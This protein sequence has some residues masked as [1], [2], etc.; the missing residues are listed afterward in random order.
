MKPLRSISVLATVLFQSALIFCQT[1]PKDLPALKGPYLGQIPP[2]NKSQIFAPD[3][4]STE[5]GE[6][7]SV[8]S[9]DGEE[10]YFSRRGIPG[11]PSAI[12]VT[13]MIN[14][15][16]TK[17]VPVDFSGVYD[18]V[19]LFIKPDGKSMIYCSVRIANKADMV[20]MDHDFL[21]SERVG[22]SWKSPVPFA[23]EATSAFEDY[24]PVVTESGNL[25]FNSQRGGTGT[26]DIFC[27]RYVNGKYLPAEKLPEPINTIY[28][29]F[30]AFVSQDEKMIIF[31]S[32]KPGGFGKADIYIS[33]K[34]SE[35][36][37]S[38]PKNPGNGINS[39]FSEY[40]ATLSPD[41]RYLFFTSNKNGSEDIFWVSAKFIEELRLKQ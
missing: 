7:N 2:G 17:P 40:G 27:S 39:E 21:M 37:W 36:G 4:V 3:F 25:Y 30:D 6:L 38:T 31:S 5:A 1:N 14:N 26:N 20:T 19:D 8:F 22:D 16:W 11:K 18:D 34:N 24:F 13:K 15:E 23:K 10:F 12:M 33:F 28:R 32:E 29:E 41:G 9:H 35:G